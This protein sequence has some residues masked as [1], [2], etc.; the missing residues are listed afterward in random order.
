M[1]LS[2]GLAGLIAL[3]GSAALA[4]RRDRDAK[5]ACLTRS[6]FPTPTLS[7][8]AGSAIHRPAAG[9]GRIFMVLL[10]TI[11]RRRALLLRSAVVASGLASLVVV[12]WEAF[13]LQAMLPKKR[14]ASSG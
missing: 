5:T 8:S 9:G 3:A 10:A 12:V 13:G 11:R 6:S 7:R 4:S 14:L 1:K 2:I